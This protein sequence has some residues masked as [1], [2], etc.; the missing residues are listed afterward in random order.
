MSHADFCHPFEFIGFMG[1][2]EG[3]EFDVMLEAKAKDLAPIR[4]RLDMVRYAPEVAR[5]FGLGASSEDVLG[6]EEAG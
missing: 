1:A 6:A 2:T 5:R 4:L 3:L